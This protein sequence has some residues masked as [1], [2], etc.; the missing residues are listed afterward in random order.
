M[1]FV[2]VH[3]ATNIANVKG[4]TCSKKMVGVALTCLI[5]LLSRSPALAI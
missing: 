3:L 4:F 2:T 1:S 5:L